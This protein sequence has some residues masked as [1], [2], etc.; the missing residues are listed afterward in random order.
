MRWLTLYARSRHV[1]VVVA[2]LLL[3]VVLTWWFAEDKWT[4]FAATLGLGLAVVF[5]ASGL[6]GQ[7]I[8]LD[9]T[10]GFSWFPRRLAHLLLIGV[11]AAGVMLAV[12]EAGDVQVESALIVRDTAGLLGLAGLAAVL[13]GGQFGWTLPLG[14]TML[15]L[16]TPDEPETLNRVF[17]WLRL[18]ADDALSWWLAGVLFVL[19]AGGY[20]MAGARR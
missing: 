10:A 5:A 14:W 11:V 9:R 15:G 8:D 1:P 12:Q 18:P 2:P 17:T 13:F 4:P 19:G 3:S 16:G 7:D 20:A 6:S